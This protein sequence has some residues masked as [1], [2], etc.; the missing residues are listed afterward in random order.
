MEE[1]KSKIFQPPKVFIPFE[2][3][4]EARFWQIGRSYRVETRLRQLDMSLEGAN[5]EV[6]ETTSL[7]YKDKETHKFLA[8]QST[9]AE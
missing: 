9:Y 3:L 2:L 4:P 5:F 6:V 7:S 8:G 1:L